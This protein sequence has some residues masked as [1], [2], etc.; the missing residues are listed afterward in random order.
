[1]NTLSD[2]LLKCGTPQ[3]V[4]AIAILDIRLANQD[5]HSGNI[6]VVDGEVGDKSHERE[7]EVLDNDAQPEHELDFE[8]AMPEHAGDSR[9]RG[10]SDDH[11]QPNKWRRVSDPH[12]VSACSA[13]GGRHMRYHLVPIDHGMCLPDFRHMLDTTFAWH[14]WPQADAPLSA[15]AKSHIRDLDAAR[16]EA[17]LRC[18]LYTSPSP[19]D[20]RGSRMP[21]SA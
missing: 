4:Q 2:F 5:R 15:E 3:D 13:S 17:R 9:S 6:L 20:Q 7:V 21:S 8:E 10:D 18:L 16:D 12:P 11:Q 1:M 19:R 14:F